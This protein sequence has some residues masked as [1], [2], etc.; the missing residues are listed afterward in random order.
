MKLQAIIA[1]TVLTLSM[2]DANATDFV[3][4]DDSVATNLCMAVA[5]NDSHALNAELRSNG[6][7]SHHFAKRHA[8]GKKLHCNDLDL[9]RF[10]KT[11]SLNKTAKVFN[12]EVTTETSI[13]DL[14]A[15]KSADT[16]VIYG[17][18]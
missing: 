2:A 8:I 15:Q 12:I 6:I 11:Y 1:A 3:A 13:K 17:S 7:A 4:A 18:H 16:V 5:S 14:S 10:T 9:V